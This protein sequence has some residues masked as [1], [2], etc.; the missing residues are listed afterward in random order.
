MAIVQVSVVPIGTASTSLSKWVAESLRVL[1]NHSD[2]KYQLTPMGTVIEGELDELFEVAREMHET[3][4]KDG[5]TRVL[6]RIS[7]DDRRDKR[8]TL[9]SKVDSV[10]KKLRE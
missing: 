6:T 7:I 4:F 8:L 1:R 5:V 10:M 2:L 9:Q 3:L